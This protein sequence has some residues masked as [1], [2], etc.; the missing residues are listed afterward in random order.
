MKKMAQIGVPEITE[1]DE[2]LAGELTETALMEYP[3]ADPVHPIHDE[4]LP[5]HGPDRV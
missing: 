3:K 4:L 2:A 5:L 1:A